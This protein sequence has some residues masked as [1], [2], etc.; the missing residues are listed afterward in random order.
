MNPK[1]SLI[2]PVYK[3]EKYLPR[4][5]ESVAAQTYDNFET[6]LVDD[7]SP[8]NCGKMCDEYAATHENVIVIHQ[9]NQGLSGARNAGVRAAT[10]E[11]V[12]FVDSDDYVSDDYIEYMLFLL[13]KYD[14]DIAATGVIQVQDNSPM[15]INQGTEETQCYSTEEALEKMCYRKLFGVSA[16][17]KLYKKNLV[18]NH[19]YPMGKLHEDVGTTYKIISDCKKVA[20]GRKRIYFYVQRTGSIMHEIITDEDF[21]SI[22]AAKEAI[23]YMETYHPQVTL[24]AK[25]LL[26]S[27]TLLCIS[28]TMSGKICDKHYF[29]MLRKEIKPYFWR[30]LIDRKS[31]LSM[32]IK[33]I[34]TMLGY[35]TSKIVFCLHKTVKNRILEE[36][37][38]STYY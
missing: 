6:I 16:C 20:F 25:S 27:E 37:R 38:K 11:Y 8:D 9:E 33:Y 28:R 26:V 23:E 10:G 21:Y 3:V 17:G 24:A 15:Y 29:N 1:V 22:S 5:L 36:K 34:A 35:N 12:A 32:K 30:V 18:D 4:C 14:A 19:P 7:G 2:I 13:Q 31:A